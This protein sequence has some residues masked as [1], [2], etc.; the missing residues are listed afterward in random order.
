LSVPCYQQRNC[1]YWI[2]LVSE[3]I[4]R[5]KTVLILLFALFTAVMSGCHWKYPDPGEP[6]ITPAANDAKASAAAGDPSSDKQQ[7]GAAKSQ[8]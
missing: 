3:T 8:P 5:A 4:M 7:D 1:S 6:V 2:D